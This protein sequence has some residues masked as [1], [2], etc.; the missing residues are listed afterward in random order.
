[1][2]SSHTPCVLY[3]PTIRPSRGLLEGLWTV[4]GVVTYD[5]GYAMITIPGPPDP[6]PSQTGAL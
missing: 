2:S 4:Y 6:P 1:M 5:L 3:A